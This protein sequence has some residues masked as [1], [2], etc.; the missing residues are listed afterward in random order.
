MSVEKSIEE[1]DGDINE[2]N[3]ILKNNVTRPNIKILLETFVEKLETEKG[4]A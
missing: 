2:L 3:T 1:L 4:K